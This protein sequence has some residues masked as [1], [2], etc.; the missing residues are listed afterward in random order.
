MEIFFFNIFWG[1]G[2]F[3]LVL[4]D[5][6]EFNIFMLNEIWLVRGKG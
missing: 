3:V 6:W 5:F 4:F 2:C 1:Y